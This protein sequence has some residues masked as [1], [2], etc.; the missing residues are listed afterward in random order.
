MAQYLERELIT[1]DSCC[2][3]IEGCG[4][5]PKAHNKHQAVTTY[6]GALWDE[7]PQQW[8]GK[9]VLGTKQHAVGS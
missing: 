5:R 7:M 6:F 2:W 4:V 9:C 3:L 1:T 8:F